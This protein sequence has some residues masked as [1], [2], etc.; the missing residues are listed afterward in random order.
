MRARVVRVALVA[1]AVALLLLAVPLAVAVRF[2]FVADENGE[3]ERDA[4]ATVVRVGPDF[5]AGDPVEL[6]GG[7]GETQRGVYD[8]TGRLRSGAGPATG[9][10]AVREARAGGVARK[11]A[12]G[13]LVIAVPVSSGERV[14]GAVRASTSARTV[15]NRVLWA[16]AALLG[17]CLLALGAAVIVARRQASV[18]SSPLEA[19]AR[20]SLAIADGDLT[21]RADHST[22]AEI[23]EVARAHNA[24]VERLA[25]LLEQ[26][27]HFTANAS[28]QLR[29]PLTGLQL[30]LEAALADPGADA[31]AALAE[32]AEKTRHLDHT[33]DE[34][35]RLATSDASMSLPSPAQ[36]VGELLEAA[37]RRWHGVLARDGRRLDVLWEPEPGKLP[38][39]GRTTD[40]ILDVLFDNAHRHGGGTV[41]VT[42]RDLGTALAVD[43]ADEGTAAL[44]SRVIFE[45]GIGEGSG[46][47]LALARELAAAAGARLALSGTAPTR[48]TLL[49]PLDGGR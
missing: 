40:Q 43:V 8:A 38:V 18:L 26:Q 36:E 47:G 15:W 42:L 35:L 6:P 44:E 20:T 5:A 41:T 23:D 25:R 4:M 10:D 30:G 49:L 29:T 37:E 11:R 9:G 27:R 19:L 33:I 31:R 28:H 45:R 2:T 16:W 39:P 14:I 24:M 46:I 32:A 21:A 12:G 7:R 22:I 1:A 34:L 13:E 17:L 48:F 3:L